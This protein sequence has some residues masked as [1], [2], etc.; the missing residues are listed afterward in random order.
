MPWRRRGPGRAGCGSA[1]HVRRALPDEYQDG[2]SAGSLVKARRCWL[3]LAGTGAL[4]LPQ[5]FSFAF[6]CPT[7]PM[8]AGLT[9]FLRYADAGG[10][11]RST[12]GLSVVGGPPWRVRGTTTAVIRSLANLEHLFMRLR[13]AGTRYDST[14]AALDLTTVEGAGTA[15]R[16]ASARAHEEGR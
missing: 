8:A 1:E 10:F 5:R 11:V 3:D 15:G 16:P 4:P 2:R 13:A 14:L 6:Q 9:S 12:G 7:A